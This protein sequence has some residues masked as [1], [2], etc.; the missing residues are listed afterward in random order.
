MK[1]Q[2]WLTKMYRCSDKL[3][4][5][6]CFCITSCTVWIFHCT[7]RVDQELCRCLFMPIQRRCL[8]IVKTFHLFLNCEASSTSST[9][10]PL[11]GRERFVGI[12]LFFLR[13]GYM[14]VSE[15]HI[16]WFCGPMTI[17]YLWCFKITL[18]SVSLY[19][20]P[21]CQYLWQKRNSIYFLK[22][23]L[24]EIGCFG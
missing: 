6:C 8:Y 20:T 7:C 10:H 17:H 2:Q 19:T 21:W 9:F 23:E 24:W 14:D 16:P 22:G 18:T 13:R 15:S 1:D 5:P 12:C 4:G 11:P 3:G